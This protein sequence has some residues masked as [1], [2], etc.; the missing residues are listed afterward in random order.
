MTCLHCDAPLRAPRWAR[1]LTALLGPAGAILLAACYG[2]PGRY[3]A[4]DQPQPI[5]MD[6]DGAAVRYECHGNYGDCLARRQNAPTLDCDD[7]D[8][9]RYPGAQDVEGDGIDQNC[10]GVDGWR[11][12]NV[13]AQPI[14]TDPA[15]PAPTPIATPP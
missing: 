4:R 3:Y 10:D 13:G 11:D 5:D 6:H 1:K 15:A 2:A 8:P 7:A 14:A 12:P 9:A